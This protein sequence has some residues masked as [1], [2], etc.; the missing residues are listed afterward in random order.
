MSATLGNRT[1]PVTQGTHEEVMPQGRVIVTDEDYL[2]S[3]ASF[4][5]MPVAAYLHLESVYRRF[6]QRWGTLLNTVASISFFAN[7]LL[8]N[9][10]PKSI[11]AVVLPNNARESAH[12]FPSVFE[13]YSVVVW[14]GEF[15][16]CGR[17][18]LESPVRAGTTGQYGKQVAGISRPI[19]TLGA[20]IQGE[21]APL[22]LTAGHA[23]I[24][25]LLDGG[26]VFSP[27]ATVGGPTNEERRIGTIPAVDDPL[28]KVDVIISKAQVD[29]G[30]VWVSDFAL[31][32][33]T[34]SRDVS[35][36]FCER[37][38]VYLE[39][40]TDQINPGHQ[41]AATRLIPPGPSKDL[42][43]AENLAR[44]QEQ[45]TLFAKVGGMTAWTDGLLLGLGAVHSIRN[46]RYQ[47]KF[48]DAAA[49][50][51]LADEINAGGIIPDVEVC[52]ITL[53][54]HV[55][56]TKRFCEQGDSGAVV[57]DRASGEAA[58]VLVGFASLSAYGQSQE[59]TAVLPWSHLVSVAQQEWNMDL[60]LVDQ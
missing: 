13:S 6:V 31:I 60:R 42:K 12:I 46:A 38:P 36:R 25:P 50:M 49:R 28:L 9:A 14:A 51:R 23:I 15:A 26:A 37:P 48:P 35:N 18:D 16:F 3:R 54:R 57:F 30:E 58:G 41:T 10:E 52:L 8:P 45:Q 24:G 2:L 43:V 55:D 56:V 1:K 27:A 20:W 44:F 21:P 53:M 11:L 47:L 22:A 33:A 29:N 39:N 17:L 32:P 5:P 7:H 19:F 4:E 59:L 34:E 40:G